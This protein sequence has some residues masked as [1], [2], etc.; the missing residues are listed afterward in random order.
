M[1]RFLFA[2]GQF[3]ARRRWW[4]L[5]LWIVLLVATAA[6]GM[7]AGGKVNDNFTVPGTESQDAVTLLKDR[8][9]AYSGA[10]MQ[11]VFATPGM[12]KVTDQPVVV[13]IQDVMSELKDLPQVADVVDPF[14]SQAVAPDQRVA[15]GNVLFAVS[16]GEVEESTLDAVERIADPAREAGLRVE[17]AGGVYPGFSAEIPHTPEVLGIIA[18]FVVLLITFGAV[19]AA[20]LPIVT[21]LVGVGIGLA[22]I[23]G[24]AA[25]VDVPSAATS[26]ALMLGLSCGIDYALFILS[27]H[28]HHIVLGMTTAESIPLAVGT[29]GSSVVFAAVTVIIAL[30]GLTVAGIPFLTVMGLTAAG[31]VLVAMLVALTLLPA[32]LAFAGGLVAKF[33]T[34]P[35]QPG[36]PAEVARIATYEPERTF[37]HTWGRFV[38]RFRV[39]LLVAGIAVLAVLAIPA[40]RMDLGLPSGA[41]ESETSTARKAYDLVSESFGAG[42]NGPLLVVADLSQ[43]TSAD[44]A[45]TLTGRLQQDPDVA[46]VRPAAAGN[47]LVLLQVIP[48]TGPADDATKDLVNRLREDREEIRSGTGATY[49]VGGATAA[50]IDTSQRLGEALPVFLAVVVGLA[51][52]L[53]TIAFRTVLVPLSSIVGFILSVFASLGVQVAA[54]Q[55]GWGAGIFDITKGQTLSFLPII[56]LAII[57]GLSSDYQIFVVSRIKEEYTRTGDAIAS[58]ENGIAHSA[59]VVTAAALIMFAVFVAFTTVDSPIVRPLALTLAIGVLLDAFIVRLTLVPAAAALI[60]ARM[61]YHPRWF[62]RYV[63]DLDIEGAELERRL[64]GRAA[65][66]SVQPG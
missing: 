1:S 41:T 19:V 21:A 58:V 42:F 32:L 54:F 62:A 47:G 56:A 30:C 5:L 35:L 7:G 25:F 61:W 53:L 6:F 38:T 15:L 43:A 23:L 13:R 27:R 24:V 63:P 33:V 3:V 16:A 40:A 14:E 51:L 36:K 4:M 28:R 12:A 59:R 9:P 17:F 48:A 46:V 45:Q 10:Q 50:N 29:A 22:G 64:A 8:L 31:A 52:V 44:A 20:G 55:W 49:L 66:E 26:L 65:A 37:G 60:G 34:P 11:V 2:L 39:P 18:A 57:F